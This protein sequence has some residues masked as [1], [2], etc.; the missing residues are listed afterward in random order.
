[1]S[2]HHDSQSWR[3]RVQDETGSEDVRMKNNGEMRRMSG[4]KDD[5]KRKGLKE[6]ASE[7]KDLGDVIGKRMNESH[8]LPPL[9]YP[10]GCPLLRQEWYS[11]CAHKYKMTGG[12][13][14]EV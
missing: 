14:K 7:G 5:K 6:Q 4:R 10:E 9:K 13:S 3:K 2:S 12:E 11:T 1:M 8:T